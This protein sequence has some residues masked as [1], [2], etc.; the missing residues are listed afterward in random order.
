VSAAGVLIVDDHPMIRGA[1]RALLSTTA[2]EVVGEASNAKEAVRAA[3]ML[4]PAVVLLDVEMPP[5]ETGISALPKILAA[6]PESRAIVFTG[7]EEPHL[8]REALAAGA[9]GYV[10]KTATGEELEAAVIRVASGNGVISARLP[11][12]ASPVVAR[13][14][15]RERDVVR[16]VVEGLTTREIAAR[17]VLSPRTVDCH[18]RS[19]IGKLGARSRSELLA[20]FGSS[21]LFG[22]WALLRLADALDAL[23]FLS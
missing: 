10:L 14:S 3:A 22:L 12:P 13:L 21:G 6:A 9:S 1:V 8:V 19:I 16:L 7:R 20:R 15:P 4:R 2:V 5:G 17:L 11:A 18:R 23:P